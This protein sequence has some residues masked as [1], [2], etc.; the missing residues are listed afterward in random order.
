M[1][2][3]PA[4]VP[5]PPPPPD[6][7]EV[8]GLGDAATLAFVVGRRRRQDVAAAEELRG[9]DQLVDDIAVEMSGTTHLG[10]KSRD[11][12]DLPAAGGSMMTR[13]QRPASSADG[14]PRRG[15]IDGRLAPCQHSGGPVPDIVQFGGAS[16]RKRR[17]R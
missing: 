15:S 12:L 10:G 6:D 9:D 17:A 14:S 4:T 16:W 2:R 13:Q 3:K 5:A 1:K 7:V 8:F 11:T